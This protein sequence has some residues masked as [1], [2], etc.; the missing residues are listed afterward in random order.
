[1][2]QYVFLNPGERQFVLTDK[3]P[4]CSAD[5]HVLEITD[6]GVKLF[7]ELCTNECCN[8]THDGKGDNGGH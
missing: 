8:L 6:D 5:V 3:T 1:M 2:N 7:D 4:S